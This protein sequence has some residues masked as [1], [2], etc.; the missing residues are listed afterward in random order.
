MQGKERGPVRL[1]S[2]S[3]PAAGGTAVLAMAMLVMA[4][5]RSPAGQ[6]GGTAVGLKRISVL[7]FFTSFGQ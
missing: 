1:C 7:L 3:A 4:A 2:R 6:G 5:T